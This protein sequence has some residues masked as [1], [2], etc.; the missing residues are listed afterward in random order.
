M[1]SRGTREPFSTRG[2]CENDQLA[3][4][5][6][7]GLP[8]PSAPHADHPPT[9]LLENRSEVPRR[10]QDQLRGRVGAVLQVLAD[11]FVEFP[12]QSQ[13]ARRRLERTELVF[14][15]RPD[16]VECEGSRSGCEEVAGQE[17]QDE[18]T[19]GGPVGGGGSP[20][21]D[22]LPPGASTGGGGPAEDRRESAA[23]PPAR[24]RAA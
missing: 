2:C 23:R 3:V 4:V 7:H 16:R 19:G 15:Q 14:L 24:A 5:R 6:G 8:S 9:R 20:E 18:P 17:V 10:K 11:T 12:F 21:S 1:R 22:P 13:H